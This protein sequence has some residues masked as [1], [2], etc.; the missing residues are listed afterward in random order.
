MSDMSVDV[1]VAV[2]AAV[3]KVL[4]DV[5]QAV[6]D[7]HG[8]II[9]RVDFSWHDRTTSSERQ[10]VVGGVEVATSSVRQPGER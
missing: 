9:Q 8:L 10:M 6:F 4:R 2:E 5:A 3:H 1:V 7:H